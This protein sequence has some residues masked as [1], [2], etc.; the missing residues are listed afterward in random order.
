MTHSKNASA[1]LESN[2]VVLLVYECVTLFAMQ[3]TVCF[4][5]RLSFDV[6]KLLD[7]DGAKS[8]LLY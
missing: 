7:L 2:D 4:N 3:T 8:I 5:K 6:Q 1:F